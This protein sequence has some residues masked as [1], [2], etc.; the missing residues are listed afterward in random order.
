MVQASVKHPGKANAPAYETK[1]KS[2]FFTVAFS[3][4]EMIAYLTIKP[5]DIEEDFDFTCEELEKIIKDA[6]VVHGISRPRL[7]KL[8]TTDLVLNKPVEVARGTAPGPGIDATFELYFETS[9]NKTPAVGEDGYIDYKNLNLIANATKGQ[10]LAKKNPPMVG[11]PGI[12]VTGKEV[13]GKPGKDKALPKGKNTEIS[14]DDPNIL[15]AVKSGAVT[16]SNSLVSIDDV[17][18]LNSDV[19]TSTG[20]IDFVG[21][22]KISGDVKAGFTVKAG[23]NIEIGKNIEDA[24]VIS[25]GSVVASG[26]FVGSGNGSI[27]AKQDVFVKYVENQK[28]RAGNDVHI[29]GGAMNAV[30]VADNAVVLQ[31]RKA[32]IVGG[33]IT[34]CNL[35]ETG[36]IGSEFGTP[37]LVRVGFNQK[38][39]NELNEIETE[40]KRLESDGKRIKEAMYS[41]V[42]LEMDNRLNDKQKVALAQ[43]REH[44]QEIPNQLQKFNNRKEE[45]QNQL[46]E[47]KKAKIIVRERV[48]PGTT[49]QIGLLK[50]DVNIILK[51]CSFKVSHDQ[52]TFYT[53]T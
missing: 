44:Q 20:N 8:A 35:I 33:S 31:G 10:P 23:G 4:D 16:Y 36:T 6:G 51:N 25:E 53:N 9:S 15:I 48:Y 30:I 18:T 3:A 45:L 39:I 26:G 42:R 7:E 19:D 22:L 49:V 13:P 2:F 43:I 41:L 37:T 1:Q 12:G 40:V 46:N 14:P 11:E 17:Y 5:T 32:V 21:S 47:N 50:K 38:I 52:I 29:G 27:I 24:V 28:I 34:A